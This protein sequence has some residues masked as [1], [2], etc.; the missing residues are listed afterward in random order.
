MKKNVFKIL[1]SL[2]LIFIIVILNNCKIEDN[3]S[4]SEKYNLGNLDHL[5]MNS[6]ILAGAFQKADDL[7][8]VYSMIVEKNGHVA[9]EYYFNGYNQDSFFNIKSVSKSI[10]SSLVGIALEKGLIKNLDQNIVDIFPDYKQFITDDRFNNI[11]L[12]HL[13]TMR[14][15]FN[16]DK[17]IFA[18]IFNS[19]NP[20]K[21]IFSEPLIY[22]PGEKMV[23]STPQT[24]LLGCTLAR[25]LKTDL[26]MFANKYL[27]T[28]LGITVDV[29]EKDPQGNFIG[30]NNMYFQARELAI[31]GRLYINEGTFANN[32]IVS[33]KWVK[34][35][36]ENSLQSSDTSWGALTNIGYGYLWW[37]GKISEYDVFSAIGYGG[38][39]ILYIPELK[40][41]VV[42]NS[43]SNLDWDV[44]DSHERAILEII[45]NYI[46]PSVN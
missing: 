6:E 30:G 39:F 23:Y 7:N 11:T 43:E 38:Q 42:I 20:L 9:G 28:S 17:S 4:L 3:I 12:R 37:L 33:D 8:F 35:S 44:A 1:F 45:K 16:D 26:K 31:F 21:T 5:G 13:L 34:Q 15:G 14:G 36:L 40:L 22:N 10:L 27:F 46:I 25:L 2:L 41:L 24:H 19:D 29:W 32:Y 18:K